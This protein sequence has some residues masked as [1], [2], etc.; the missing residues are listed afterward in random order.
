MKY[1]LKNRITVEIKKKKKQT[2][3]AER[4]RC[5]EI[6]ITKKKLCIFLNINVC[7]VLQFTLLKLSNTVAPK[8]SSAP[9]IRLVLMD[10]THF[11]WHICCK[12]FTN[13]N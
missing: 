2:M 7:C 13:F 11:W 12:Q 9:F 6:K 8:I 10:L 4:E 3:E 5:K 1:Y